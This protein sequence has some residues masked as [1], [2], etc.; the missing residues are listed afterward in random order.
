MFKIYYRIRLDLKIQALNLS[1]RAVKLILKP[2]ENSISL[3]SKSALL[4]SKRTLM[5]QPPNS[6]HKNKI[7]SRIS[8]TVLVLRS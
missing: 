1:F 7:L 8:L 2:L 4:L 6:K 3:T 5:N